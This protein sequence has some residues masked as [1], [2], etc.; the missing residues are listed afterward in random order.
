MTDVIV[1]HAA[2]PGHFDAAR[3]AA[4][5]ERL[6]YARRLELERRDCAA[7]TASLRGLELLRDGVARLR[8]APLD[9]SQ[10]RFPVDR[11]PYLEGGPWFSISHSTSRVAVAL[12][13]RCDLGIDV[14][15]LGAARGGRAALER[16]TATEAALKAIGYGVRAALDVR[17]AA[18]LAT[19]QL[20]D[21]VVYTRSVALSPDCLARI[22][23]RQPVW[24]VVV[25]G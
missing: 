17:L 1:F 16:W 8:G 13:D 21:Q 15:D 14:E 20:A 5:L 7:R 9:M 2:R 23:T 22:A 25:V 3:A 4:L 11:K 6:P 12:S 18:D 24:Q 10:L 19:A